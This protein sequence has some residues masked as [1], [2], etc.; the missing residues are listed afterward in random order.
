MMVHRSLRWLALL[1]VLVLGTY[2]LFVGYRYSFH[3]DGAIKSV[4]AAMAWNEGHV[5]PRAWVY[6]NGDTFLLGPQIF[7]ELLYPF[8]GIS[9]AANAASDWLA[10]LVLA[11]SVYVACR[12][13]SPTA[14]QGRLVAV[15]VSAGG[16]GAANFEFVLGQ[17]AYALYAAV[18]I[19][20]FAIVAREQAENTKPWIRRGVL[21][22]AFATTAVACT[23]NASRGVATVLA[24]AMAGCFMAVILNRRSD[25]D[26][27]RRL[28]SRELLAT[29]AGGL[30][31][32]L[33]YRRVV[34][35]EL[36]NFQAAARMKL[37]S[38]SVIIEHAL[39]LPGAW[40]SYFQVSAAWAHLSPSMRLLQAL[41]WLLSIALVLFPAWVVVRQRCYPV[42]IVRFAWIVLA[43]YGIGTAALVALADLYT[44]FLEL[45]YL[46]FAI[47]ASV[48]LIFICLDSAVGET[49]QAR[50][51]ILTTACL[52]AVWMAAWNAMARSPS[53]RDNA[54]SYE[55]RMALVASL[56][57]H[58]VGAVLTPYWY[59]HVLTVLSDGKTRAFPWAFNDRFV[60]FAHHMPRAV[61]QGS[62]GDIQAIML[63][64][65][66]AATQAD[67]L[68]R[69][70]GD[71]MAKW[72]VAGMTLLSYPLRV[73][74]DVVAG[75]DAVNDPVPSAEV[76]VR[77]DHGG[78]PA[79]NQPIACQVTVDAYNDGR[80]VLSPNGDRPFRLGLI[81]LGAAGEVVVADAG[82]AQF[83]QAIVPGKRAEV[84]VALPTAQGTKIASYRLCLLQENVSWLCEGTHASP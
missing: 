74:D 69:Q 49:D 46:S 43:A 81:G 78:F 83:P 60:P 20:L 68:R 4:L 36:H 21:V 53:Q 13:L 41:V 73:V 14:N 15:V 7:N 24:P 27:V 75:A 58:H 19:L 35:P 54:G 48:C 66:D 32:V 64:D 47:Y 63:T 70:F 2:T 76:S 25:D 33:L 57:E 22:F 12:L 34:M 52:M 65:A 10:F 29:V 37:A 44:S 71:P 72:S 18:A 26:L 45:R 1:V 79:C 39:S 23:S 80:R 84:H 28:F 56:G 5:I 59:S 61:V 31:G 55:D 8:L 67:S 40:F 50:R 11:L 62:A 3:S 42:G 16:L 9:Y 82:R 17:G 38:G 6:A 51:W 30:V 77:L